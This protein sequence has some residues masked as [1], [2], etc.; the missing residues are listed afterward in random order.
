[1]GASKGSERTHASPSSPERPWIPS[2][3]RTASLNDRLALMVLALVAVMVAL[4]FQ[5]YGITWDEELQATYGQLLWRFYASGFQ[6]TAAFHYQNLYL[7]GGLFDLV[8]TA[9]CRVSPLGEYETRHLL[10]GAVG[11]LG[12]AGTWAL[13][14]RLHGPRAGLLALSLLAVTPL[15]YGHMFFN[16]KDVPFACGMVW[17]L[18][19]LVRLIEAF[20]RPPFARLAAFGVISGLTLATR[21][22]AVL[23]YGYLAVAWAA[24]A[25]RRLPQTPGIAPIRPLQ[26]GIRL[27]LILPI[28]Y[29]AMVLGWPWAIASWLNPL[30]ALRAFAHFDWPGLVLIQGQWLPAAALPWHY[31]LLFFVIQL[32]ELLLL[33]LG[34]ALAVLVWPRRLRCGPPDLRVGIVALAALFP[35]VHFILARPTAYHTVRH[36]LFV[37]PPLC[38]LAA[39]GLDRLWQWLRDR[40]AR[41]KINSLR[42]VWCLALVIQAVRMVTLH[43]N[44]YIYYN[45]FVGGVTGA[46]DRFELDY[47]G[48]SL[49]EATRQLTALVAQEDAQRP[50]GRAYRVAVGGHPLSVSYFLPS[51]FALSTDVEHADFVVSLTESHM[52]VTMPGITVATV[53]R[54]GA[55]LA[56]VKDHRPHRP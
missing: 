43:P 47:W 21:V 36:Y 39:V 49:K 14:R 26:D 48:S 17:S 45:A 11:L 33:G 10:G 22:G 37:I 42:A 28:S 31:L 3:F 51:H 56:V 2:D 16:A 5:D 55:V 52:D 41:P 4:T 9:L 12:L 24:Y 38:V 44:E 7:Y 34:A 54:E 1:M 53:A 23:L 13:A 20:P 8:A 27:L 40:L 25:L 35:L 6:D 32:P 19:S 50:I 30:Q 46:N 15:Y 18:Y 29:G